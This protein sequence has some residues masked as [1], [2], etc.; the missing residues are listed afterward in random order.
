M[1][2]WD[3]EI[4]KGKGNLGFETTQGYLKKKNCKQGYF[5]NFNLNMG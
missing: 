3:E 2:N 5:I 4:G 1:F